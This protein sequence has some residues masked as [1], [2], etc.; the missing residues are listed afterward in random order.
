MWLLTGL[1]SSSLGIPYRAV[2]CMAAGFPQRSILIQC[3]RGLYKGVSTRRRPPWRLAITIC[4]LGPND[5][6]LPS[7]IKCA[8][9]IPRPLKFS[10]HYSIYSKSRI[11]SSKLGPGSRKSPQVE[12]LVYGSL[13]T[14]S[15]NLKTC[16][17][18]R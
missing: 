4:H 1:S 9:P 17:L 13:S 14:V 10:S 15:L 11:T 16:E 18:K 8:H 12:C 2:H 5:S 7:H 3:G 6:C